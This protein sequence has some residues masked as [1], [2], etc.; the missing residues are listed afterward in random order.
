MILWSWCTVEA[1]LIYGL[2]ERACG[3]YFPLEKNRVL[4]SARPEWFKYV[5][6]FIHRRT[7]VLLIYSLLL[8]WRV[9]W[10]DGDHQGL[11]NAWVKSIILWS[12][13]GIRMFLSDRK[14]NLLCETLTKFFMKVLSTVVLCR[15]QDIIMRVFSLVYNSRRTN[16]YEQV[17][18]LHRSLNG[19]LA[20]G[21]TEA[22]SNWFIKFPNYKSFA[23]QFHLPLALRALSEDQDTISFN[24]QFDDQ[25]FQVRTRTCIILKLPINSTNWLS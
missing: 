10:A 16:V 18:D 23:Y 11:K 7:V 20:S 21:L 15:C 17:S 25:H 1:L 22:T 19:S 5:L 13:P 3:K 4:D 12:V 24:S 9:S 2:A 8:I 6:S 14:L